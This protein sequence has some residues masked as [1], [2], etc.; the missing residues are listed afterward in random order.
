V[1]DEKA[2]PLFARRSIYVVDDDSSMRRSMERLLRNHGFTAVVFESAGAL[3][4]HGH[5]EDA[6]CLVLD[7]NLNGESGIALR[8]KLASDG[9]KVPVVY[10][11]GNDSQA[12][13]A[14]AI[15]SGCAA[16]L[17]KPFA[18]SELIATV[19]RACAKS[20]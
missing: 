11:T 7:V 14:A 12:N 6:C 5:L 8:R 1:F 17:S 13:Q 4:S 18:A 9:A 10:I 2:H 19:E 3:L 16:Y 15:D 20:A